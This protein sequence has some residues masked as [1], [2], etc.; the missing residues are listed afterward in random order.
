MLSTNH[1][2]EIVAGI[3]ASGA[4]VGYLISSKGLGRL[5]LGSLPP[6]AL[7]KWGVRLLLLHLRML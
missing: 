7:G 1:A 2:S 5:G 3:Q 4:S 6:F